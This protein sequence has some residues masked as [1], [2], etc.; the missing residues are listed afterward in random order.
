MSDILETKSKSNS[1]EL[2]ADTAAST[3]TSHSNTSTSGKEGNALFLLN[4]KS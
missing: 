4:V 3:G 2:S 1:S